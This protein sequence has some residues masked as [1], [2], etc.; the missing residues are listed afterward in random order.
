M[1]RWFGQNDNSCPNCLTPH[2]RADHLCC[3]P[4]DEHTQLL[5]DDTMELAHWLKQNDLTHHEIA[6]W[7]PK[8]ILCRGTVKFSEL[9]LM[10]PRMMKLAVSQDT[11]GRRNFMEGWISK[12]FLEIQCLHICMSETHTW[13]T[14]KVWIQMFISKVLQVS[15]SQWLFQNFTLHDSLAGYLK[16]EEKAHTAAMIT[17]LMRTHPSTLPKES[18]FVLEFNT[19][20]LLWSDKNTQHYWI[21]SVEAAISAKPSWRVAMVA[22]LFQQSC[23]A[24]PEST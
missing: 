12:H 18:Q 7:V 5:Q 8:Y 13:I 14:A 15:H 6:Y 19:D 16:T 1:K 2:E 21:L 24:T 11:I 22:P 3:C 20:S 4:S 23:Q 17:V 10:S 9:G